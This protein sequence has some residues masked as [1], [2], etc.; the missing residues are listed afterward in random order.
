[1]AFVLPVTLLII[2]F[3]CFAMLLGEGLWG[4]AITFFNVVTAALLSMNYFEPVAGLIEEQVGSL[5]YF[6]DFIAIWVLFIVAYLIMKLICERVSRVKVRFRKPVETVGGLL[7]AALVGWIMVSFS[8]TTFHTAPVEVNSFGGGFQ[9]EPLDKMFLGMAAPDRSW[10]AFIYNS[11]KG[12]SLDR[13]GQ[14]D[15][16]SNFDPRADFIYR[17]RLRREEL[18]GQSGMFGS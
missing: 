14:D 6:A 3:V 5:K 2:F 1:M 15:E 16:A 4:N 10:L 11:S 17:Y 18:A 7:F 9:K 13:F 8:L 12:G